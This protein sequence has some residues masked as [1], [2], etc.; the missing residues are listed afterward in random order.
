MKRTLLTCL[1]LTF[2]VLGLF[3]S[4]NAET[5]VPEDGVGYIR[6]GEGSRALSPS[7]QTVSYDDVY[8]FYTAKK[9]D[10]YGTK[11]ETS[12]L[13]PVTTK[14]EN[15][16]KVPEKG[17][18]GTVG[19]FSQGK[20]IFTLAAYKELETAGNAP[21]TSTII[22][23][24]G[25]FSV[26]LAGGET[27]S[28]S[29]TVTAKGE[30]GNLVFDGATFN[31]EVAQTQTGGEGNNTAEEPLLKIVAKR[32]TPT[33]D[34][35]SDY[36]TYTL[37]NDETVSGATKITLTSGDKQKYTIA[38]DND[39]TGLE[40]VTVDEETVKS[41]PMEK[42]TYQCTVAAYIEGGEGT[43]IKEQTFY[44][45]IYLGGAVTK[46]SGDLTED[47]SSNVKFDVA[48]TETV[49]KALTLTEDGKS[50]AMEFKSDL[51][52][53]DETTDEDTVVVNLVE[54]AVSVDESDESSTV[55]YALNVS[56]NKDAAGDNSFSVQTKDGSE[57]KCSIDLSLDKLVD[58]VKTDEIS[59]FNEPVEIK[60][61][62]GTGLD[63]D[64]L[65]VVYTG[66]K[67]TEQPVFKSYDSS[68]GYITF[69]TTH[70]S[71]FAVLYKVTLPVVKV[72][73]NGKTT[74]YQ[75]FEEAL[76]YALNGEFGKDDSITLLDDVDLEG[77]EWTPLFAG[78]RTGSGIKS[79][80]GFKGT[81]DGGGNTISNLKITKGDAD[82]CVGLFGILDGGVIK[83][84]SLTNVSVNASDCENVG[85]V[86]GLMCNGAALD[87]VTVG[88][89]DKAE[90]SSVAGKAAGGVVGRMIVNCSISNCTNYATVNGGEEGAGGIVCKAYYSVDNSVQK[91]TG[92]KNYG[93][94][95]STETGHSI[96]GI[97]AYALAVEIS[98]CEN[99]GDI[100]GVGVA[101]GGIVG[102][103][104]NKGSVSGSKNM[105]KISNTSSSSGIYGLGGIVGW[106]RYLSAGVTVSGKSSGL[107]QEELE[108][109]M[110]AIE[111]TGNENTGIIDGVTASSGAGGIVGMVFNTAK[112]DNNTNTASK[113]SGN[114]F[115]SGI[116]GGHQI[117]SE[118]YLK[119][120]IKNTEVIGN[121]STT[122]TESMTVGDGGCK[123]DIIY[124]NPNSGVSSD[125]VTK[126]GG[127]T[128]D[129][130]DLLPYTTDEDGTKICYASLKDAFDGATDGATI[131]LSGDINLSE[132]L[133]ITKNLTLDMAGHN[134]TCKAP[135]TV[136]KCST[137]G[138]VFELKNSSETI[139]TIDGTVTSGEG[140][141]VKGCTLAEFSNGSTLEVNP[142]I[143]YKGT[144]GIKI[145]SA[146]LNYYGG[147]I[148][149]SDTSNKA[150]MVSGT[151][152]K[153]GIVNLCGNFSIQGSIK[154]DGDTTTNICGG[155]IE[156]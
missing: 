1:I 156:A 126:I 155:R 53:S 80:K 108:S 100:S 29:V 124:L 25:S 150:V 51:A 123:A 109:V 136:F 69:T 128:P 83:N 91:I 36:P 20:W 144:E 151:S 143:T 101:I 90:S 24:G 60:I 88:S 2:V 95:T 92:C 76:A 104:R 131:N 5:T 121:T 43:P 41:L 28:V 111:V 89:S 52:T 133:V 74:Y 75:S 40:D 23:D 15:D 78:T 62:I 146:T 105:G 13:T 35:G 3:V 119:G 16:A 139:S 79:G 7:Y 153:Q 33:T 38:F 154:T 57:V 56:V 134:I 149:L 39:N 66:T 85:A 47:A 32:T 31:Y 81:F 145:T 82:A 34:G 17:L 129:S 54:G 26:A 116:V 141:S 42:G 140:D 132:G 96:G 11:G 45:G 48:K 6:F 73:R 152:D 27:K 64:D 148:E 103:F 10:G 117:N 118:N 65:N 37:T 70:F 110:S 137:D 44:F 99:H 19:E 120:E 14:E 86:V 55:D 61:F 67:Y 12:T 147:S 138:V 98:D 97:A 50:N 46:I 58:G 68:S 87:N 130:Q 107:T 127:N 84:L 135:I 142:Y 71:N 93:A 18:S 30:Y 21:N 125:V 9:D 113:I 72:V 59:E 114:T 77:E 22:Y 94:I 115:V 122:K 8:W 102:E 106:V 112:V 4:C 49:V 63:E